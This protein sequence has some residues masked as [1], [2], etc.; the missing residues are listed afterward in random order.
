MNNALSWL[1]EQI[2]TITKDEP[3]TILVKL[4]TAFLVV[5]LLYLVFGLT[6]RA[7]EQLSPEQVAA[8]LA[9]IGSVTIAEPP[10]PAEPAPA[11]ATAPAAAPAPVAE[12]AAAEP[13][14]AEAPAA[15]TAAAEAEA[16]P[17]AAEAPAAETASA[18]PTGTEAPVAETAAAEPAVAEA[19][20]A[21]EPAVAEAPVAAEAPAQPMVPPPYAAGPNTFTVPVAPKH[22]GPSREA[23]R[24]APQFSPMPPVHG[25]R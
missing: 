12:S 17:A 25:Y 20:A 1:A 15:E 2:S 5:G 19:P 13:A 21:A 4:T 3:G 18:E 9:P 16:P 11:P 7:T 8:N 24:W 10:P 6:T 22:L 23:P 14:K